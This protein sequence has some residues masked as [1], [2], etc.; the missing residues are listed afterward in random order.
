MKKK[1][2]WLTHLFSFLGVI[3]GVYLAFYIDK[4]ATAAGERKEGQ[5]LMKS[6]VNDLSSDINTYENYQIP[7]NATYQKNVDSLLT[8]LSAN[9][10]EQVR[11][12]LPAI[13]QVEN[14][15]PNTSV[16]NSMK[17]SGKIKFVD[18]LDIQKRL[19]DF[20]DGTVLECD[21]KNEIQVDYFMNEVM[22]WLTANVDLMEMRFFDPDD[23]TVLRN[24]LLIYG[25][26]VAQKVK[27]YEQVLAE[28]RELREQLGGVVDD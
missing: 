26:L 17:S 4:S 27:S 15:S 24:K 9:N 14:Y 13:F 3:L 23:L 11:E 12:L 18:N 1:F 8:L 20:Y 7:V 6:M 22:S 21:K 5:L 28:S 10:I 25:S 19:S 16:Y 2:D